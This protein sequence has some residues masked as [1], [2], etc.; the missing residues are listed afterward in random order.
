MTAATDPVAE[1]LARGGVV[2]KCPTAAIAATEAKVPA[3][4]RARLAAYA[5][6]QQ[7]DINWRKA[8]TFLLNR[9]RREY[10]T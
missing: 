5:A 3:D 4:D 10:P 8:R 1:F 6:T 7:G 2:T 9:T